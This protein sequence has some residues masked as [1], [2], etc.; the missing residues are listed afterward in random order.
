MLRRSRVKL[1]SSG[2]RQ[3]KLQSVELSE[4]VDY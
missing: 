1:I 4:A 3:V 2:R